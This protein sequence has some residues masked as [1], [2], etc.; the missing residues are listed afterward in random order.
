M[1]VTMGILGY[2][3]GLLGGDALATISSPVSGEDTSLDPLNR[4][5]TEV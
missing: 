1:D 3:V 4:L 2:A 5:Y